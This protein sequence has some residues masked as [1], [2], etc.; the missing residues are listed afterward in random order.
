M[1]LIKGSKKCKYPGCKRETYKSDAYFC[2]EHSRTVK[3]AGKKTT[4]GFF[5]VAVTAVGVLYKKTKD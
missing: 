4:L 2:L 3:D 1:K 5:A